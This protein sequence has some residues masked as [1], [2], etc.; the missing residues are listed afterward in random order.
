[1]KPDGESIGGVGVEMSDLI[2][3]T[4][5][6]AAETATER[7]FARIAVLESVDGRTITPMTMVLSLTRL[8]LIVEG[9][10]VVRAVFG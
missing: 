1:M 3:M 4:P 6:F 2:G 7:G 9:G 5:E 10:K 8:K